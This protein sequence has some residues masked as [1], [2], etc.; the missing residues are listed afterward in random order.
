MTLILFLY[1][2]E[3][4]YTPD[5]YVVDTHSAPIYYIE[6]TPEVVL[7]D[8]LHITGS[9]RV[10]MYDNSSENSINFWPVS[11]SSLFDIYIE[12]SVI[13]IG[14]RHLCQHPIVPWSIEHYPDQSFNQAYDQFYIRLSN[15]K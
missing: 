2:L 9:A 3:L 14:Y 6:F 11:V 15:K 1:S 10:D 13:A 12:Y 7:F 4:G 5:H 8:L